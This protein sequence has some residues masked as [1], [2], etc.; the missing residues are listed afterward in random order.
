MNSLERAINPSRKEKHI[1]L[2]TVEATKKGAEELQIETKR[3]SFAHRKKGQTRQ[4][5][6]WYWKEFENAG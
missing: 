4:N 5:Q 6:R 1:A 2:Y 3:T